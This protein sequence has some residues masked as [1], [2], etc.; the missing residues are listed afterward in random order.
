MATPVVPLRT[1]RLG[2]E[3][4]RVP[5]PDQDFMTVLEELALAIDELTTRIEILESEVRALKDR[6]PSPAQSH[7]SFIRSLEIPFEELED[8][9]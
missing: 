4:F 3:E 6:N 2:S 9:Q 7:E 5:V 1:R 8:V